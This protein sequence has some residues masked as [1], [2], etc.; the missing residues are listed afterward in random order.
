MYRCF[1]LLIDLIEFIPLTDY[2]IDPKTNYTYMDRAINRPYPII[3]IKKV[4][5]VHI[6]ALRFN[7]WAFLSSPFF[8]A[9][10]LL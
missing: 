2:F 4:T 5:P 8:H 9:F 1:I 10:L 6:L 7:S 3:P